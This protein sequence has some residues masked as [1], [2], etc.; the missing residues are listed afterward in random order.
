MCLNV[1]DT[2]R[3]SIGI[4]ANGAKFPKNVVDADASRFSDR[5][6]KH[7]CDDDWR[8]CWNGNW[9]AL[10]PQ[11]GTTRQLSTYSPSEVSHDKNVVALGIRLWRGITADF[12]W[13]TNAN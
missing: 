1:V 9:G 13:H 2:F 3:P 7:V 8:R 10:H 5:L 4:F 6:A 11:T 12:K